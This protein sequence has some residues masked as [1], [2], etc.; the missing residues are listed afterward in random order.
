MKICLSC[1]KKYN[2]TESRCPY[3]GHEEILYPVEPIQ[4]IPGTVLAKRYLL[5]EAIGTGGFGIV[6]KAWD[7][8]LETIVAIKE[9]FVSRL[10][11]RAEGTQMLI[12][13]QKS[14]KEFNYR[15]E[16]FLAE[17]RHMAEFSNHKSM[18]NVFEFFE[19]NNTA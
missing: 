7:T 1:F 2:N 14:K 9:F 3:C 15:K 5:G 13:S 11:T 4:L 17:A 19:E 18:P 8:K 12:V 16:R 10:S 6:Y